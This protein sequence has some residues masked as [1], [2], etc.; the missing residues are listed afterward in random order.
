MQL[1]EKFDKAEETVLGKTALTVS[2]TDVEDLALSFGVGI[3][4]AIDLAVAG[5][6]GFRGLSIDGVVFTWDTGNSLL[7]H[8]KVVITSVSLQIIDYSLDHHL[9][10]ARSFIGFDKAK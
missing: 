9:N 6:T 1:R 4:T 2:G 10:Y 3:I 7:Q 8:G 5:K